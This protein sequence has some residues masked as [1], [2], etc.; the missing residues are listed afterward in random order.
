[1]L[2]TNANDLKYK[3]R[4]LEQHILESD[5][6][7]ICVTE[8]MFN[9]NILDAEISIS[10]SNIFRKDRLGKGGGG[11]CIF[12]HNSLSANLIDSFDVPDCIAV[13]IDTSPIPIVVI[14]VYRS[15]SLSIDENYYL[16]RK[17]DNFC[18]RKTNDYEIIMTG[19]F[20]LPN[21]KWDD[22][23][24]DGYI[25]SRNKFINVQKSFLDLFIKHNFQC[26]LDDNSI[27]RR[28][29][30]DGKLQQSLLD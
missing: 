24:I 18:N 25:D 21:L 2:Y 9:E 27:T 14:C 17:L 26:L 10:N 13:K 16:I 7:I 22:S 6:K 4:E 15:T 11:S 20:N 12:V 1:M 29:W 30:V 28:R 3:I 5:C 19:D 23:I 8:T